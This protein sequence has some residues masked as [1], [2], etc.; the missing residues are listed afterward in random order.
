GKRDIVQ[1]S[2]ELAESNDRIKQASDSIREPVHSEQRV[3]NELDHY[4]YLMNKR[5]NKAEIAPKKSGPTM[6][7]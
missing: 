4:Q 2:R 6:S 1:A 7:M 3:R 5:K